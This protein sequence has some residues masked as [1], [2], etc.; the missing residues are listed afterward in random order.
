MSILDRAR[1][2][3]GY[4]EISRL[5]Q[6]QDL[7]W[8]LD[9]APAEAGGPVA[10]ADLGCGTGTLLERALERWPGLERAV[11][12]DGA[13][14]RVAETGGRLAADGRV[15]VRRGD[16]L[17]LPDDAGERFDL[18]TLTSVLHWLYPDESRL[19]AWI[20]RHLRPDGAFLLTT[21]HPRVERDG[22]GA[23]DL[24][25]AEALA[26]LGVAE[27]AGAVPISER[28]RTP[29][30]I[31]ALLAEHLELDA[32]EERYATQQTASPEQHAAFHASTFGTYFSRLVPAADEE[33]F[34]AEVGRAAWR[35]QQ[36]RGEIYPITVRLW[37]ARPRPR[38]DAAPR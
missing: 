6:A 23:E 24:V 16:L 2:L 21:H 26:A 38:G 5:R 1:D 10:L 14:S 4:D 34:F 11:G 7:D 22:R 13:A 37:R 29:D 36:E 9:L 3:T 8:V 19:L 25:V 33:R 27:P 31:K 35:R 12:I 30:A 18:I 32:I 17:A 28:T 15:E 20:A